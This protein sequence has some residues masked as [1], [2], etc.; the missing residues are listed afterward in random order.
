MAWLGQP[1][2]LVLRRQAALGDR[3]RNAASPTVGV[4]CTARP[5]RAKRL[6]ALYLRVVGYSLKTEN[7]PLSYLTA[8]KS[9]GYKY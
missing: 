1:D 9:F 8:Y 5:Q 2:F 6:S 3:Q 4:G 7:N